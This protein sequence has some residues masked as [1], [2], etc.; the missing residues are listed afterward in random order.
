MC[1][2]VTTDSDMWSFG[3]PVSRPPKRYSCSVHVSSIGTAIEQRQRR[4]IIRGSGS[5]RTNA[6]RAGLAVLS[7]SAAVGG[8]AST[9]RIAI[10]EDLVGCW[11]L[12]AGP[13]QGDDGSQ[14]DGGPRLRADRFELDTAVFRSPLWFPQT[15]EQAFVAYSLV[16]TE[17]RDHPYAMWIALPGDS[18]MI[19]HPAAYAGVTLRLHVARRDSLAGHAYAHSD[20]ALDG[21]P[22]E[23]RARVVARRLGCD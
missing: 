8:C 20:V 16:D 17:R 6:W 22:A 1:T 9:D 4:C 14:R 15:G 10:P 13:W 2:V 3:G 7:L 11:M 12:E 19:G 18:I 23:A 5:E 21:S